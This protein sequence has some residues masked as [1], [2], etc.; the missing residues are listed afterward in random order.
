MTDVSST[1]LVTWSGAAAFWFIAATLVQWLFGIGYPGT[2]FLA[3]I[4]SLTVMCWEMRRVQRVHRR[5]RSLTQWENPL[6]FLIIRDTHPR[7]G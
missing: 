3:A 2:C 6:S 5:A 1:Q 7:L 4:A